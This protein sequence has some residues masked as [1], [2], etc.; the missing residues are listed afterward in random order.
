MLVGTREGYHDTDLGCSVSRMGIEREDDLL[1]LEGAGTIAGSGTT[2]VPI[3]VDAYPLMVSQEG[4]CW[5]ERGRE[6][7]SEEGGVLNGGEDMKVSE[8]TDDGEED[9][10]FDG[11]IDDA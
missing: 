2:F 10:G 4:V 6:G 5:A 7:G 1:E 3:L 11:S 9:D 8:S